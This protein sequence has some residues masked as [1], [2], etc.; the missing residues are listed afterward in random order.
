MENVHRSSLRVHTGPALPSTECL[1]VHAP[2][3]GLGCA[4][5]ISKELIAARNATLVVFA[6]NGSTLAAWMSRVP[7][8]RDRLEL[9]P[10][11]L[12]V[13][14]LSFSL[15][16]LIS[17]PLA[18]RIVGRIGAARGVITGMSGITLGFG[19]AAIA[20]GLLAPMQL[21]MAMLF[22]AGL[23]MGLCDV[24]MNL[25]GSAVERGVRRAIMPWFHAAFS[26]GTV[27][28]ALL[29]AA[30]VYLG[31]SLVLHLVGVVVVALA[32]AVWCCRSFIAAQ[33]D[34]AD[35]SPGAARPQNRSAWLESRT[36][37]IG[38]MVLAA[39]FA[40]G[41]ANDWL[42]VAFIDGHRVSNA[43]G[44]LALAVF[45]VFM[46]AGR[47]LGTSLLDR[48]GRVVVLRVLFTLAILGSLMVVFGNT[49]IAYL[50]AAVWGLGASLGFPVGMSA[51]SDEPARAHARISVVSTI[52][53]LAFI[54][55]PPLLGFLGDHWGVLRALSVVM[56]LAVVALLV[57]P[58]ADPQRVR[59]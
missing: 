1:V 23:G 36:L 14:L 39:A 35:L 24:S 21:V 54:A 19:W 30:L 49:A 22:V 28:S 37:L 55:G 45:L 34:E 40:E 26:A 20:V 38:V 44:V 57:V 53:Y 51:A 33:E 9:T 27:L 6:A 17:L 32:A 52:G 16:S 46:T 15:G 31:V 43:A 5:P 8:V 59:H 29:G 58:A 10:G 7:Q 11:Q 56:V 47:M 2:V 42:A 12:G 18:G 4:V 48:H 3:P 25:H 41:T 13:L 50:G